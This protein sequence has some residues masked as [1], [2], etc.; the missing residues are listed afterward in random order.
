MYRLDNDYLQHSLQAAAD[1]PILQQY[2]RCCGDNKEQEQRWALRFGSKISD[3]QLH[4]MD[5]FFFYLFI[6]LWWRVWRG[7][8]WPGGSLVS[9]VLQGVI[10]GTVGI[11]CALC[12]RMPVM[13]RWWL[14]RN[15]RSYTWNMQERDSIHH[16]NHHSA[17]WAHFPLSSAS[18]NAR[19]HVEPYM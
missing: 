14:M 9:L 3:S 5:F 2:A 8:H 6:F 15:D 1:E 4:S 11:S 17:V 7:D 12:T 16:F 13:S 18:D 19:L 10:K